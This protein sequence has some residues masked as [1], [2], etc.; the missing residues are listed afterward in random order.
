MA[1]RREA[2]EWAVQLLFQLDLNPTDKLDAVFGWFWET[3]EGDK[4][5]RTFAE[6]LVRGVLL[7]RERIDAVMAKHAEN[8]DVDRM[9]VLDRN[10][11]RMALFEMLLRPDIPPVVSINEAVEIAKHFSNAE[12]G[13]FVNGILDKARRELDRPARTSTPAVRPHT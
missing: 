7:N 13:K 10:V 4:R 1:T 8:W 11:L 5:T 12:S 3:V 6:E 2:R 9:S